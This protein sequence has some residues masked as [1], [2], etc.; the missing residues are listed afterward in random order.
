MQSIICLHV[1]IEIDF[2]LIRMEIMCCPKFGGFKWRNIM[3]HH[4]TLQFMQGKG[5]SVSILPIDDEVFIVNNI[6]LPEFGFFRV[7]KNSLIISWIV[8]EFGSVSTIKTRA[9]WIFKSL[10]WWWWF[11]NKLRKKNFIPCQRNGLKASRK[12]LFFILD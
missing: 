4:G 5:W 12:R 11:V 6:Y 7:F 10:N 1:R 8:I 2:D 3:L 9:F